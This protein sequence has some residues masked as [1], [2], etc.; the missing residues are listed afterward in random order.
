[1]K[2]TQITEDDWAGTKNEGCQ[3]DCKSVAQFLE[4]V[5]KLNGVNKTLL[6]AETAE[7]MLM[8]VGGG[9]DGRFIVQIVKNVDEEFHTLCN[10]AVSGTDALEVVSGG[11]AGMY[12]ARHCVDKETALIACRHFATTAEPSPDLSWDVEG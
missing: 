4:G 8:T 3:F 9:N 7:N 11:Q 10:D 12:P 6:V 1:M 2:I 5:H